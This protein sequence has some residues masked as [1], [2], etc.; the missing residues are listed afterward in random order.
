MTA[1]EARLHLRYT[2][3]ASRRLVD[4]A[5]Q[6]E[7]EQRSR[8]MGVSHHSVLGTLG[9]VHFGDRIWYTRVIDPS[10]APLPPIDQLSTLEAL[11][12]DWPELQRRWVDW[13]DSLSDS[14][15]DQMVYYSGPG[16]K[17]NRQQTWKLILHVVNHGTLHRGQVMAMLRQLGVKPPATD[18]IFYYRELDAAAS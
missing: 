5:A 3:W 18:L 15:L 11:Q 16:G 6:L 8:P 2:G 10:L 17:P 9:H 1:H 14:D 12:K 7:P 13:A 4:A